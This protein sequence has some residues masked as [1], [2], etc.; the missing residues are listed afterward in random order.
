MLASSALIRRKF[1]PLSTQT[2]PHDV[3][4]FLNQNNNKFPFFLLIT[5]FL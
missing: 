5:C 1:A 4:A 3:S 2:V